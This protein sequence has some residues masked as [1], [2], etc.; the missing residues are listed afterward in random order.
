MREGTSTVPPHPHSNASHGF[1]PRRGETRWSKRLGRFTKQHIVPILAIWG[2]FWSVATF[3]YK[4]VFQPRTAPV[5]ISLNLDLKKVNPATPPADPHSAGM[6]AVEMQLAATN[7]SGREIFLLPNVW[8]AY[9]YRVS[10]AAESQDFAERLNDTLARPRARPVERF[11][12]ASSP[13]AVPVA[14][15]VLLSDTNLKPGE[16]VARTLVFHVPRNTFDV[17]EVWTA[18]PTTSKA[19]KI[20]LTWRI[21]NNEMVNDVR[22]ND[23]ER[24]PLKRDA[25][26]NYIDKD[27]ELQQSG[28]RFALSLIQ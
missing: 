28:S 16:K 14:G 25:D 2:T 15:G 17:I 13:V 9:G 3:Y 4:D 27:L 11:T 20:L 12:R 6:I 24:R 23:K 19:G 5:N 1:A 22:Y 21:E 18:I 26:G 8:I 10:K 7:P